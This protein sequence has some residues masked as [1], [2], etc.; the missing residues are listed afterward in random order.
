MTTICIIMQRIEAVRPIGFNT[1]HLDV[2]CEMTEEQMRYAFGE[3]L[4]N[5]SREELAEWIKHYEL[6]DIFTEKKGGT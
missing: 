6:E 2:E 1:R 4:K 5:V 3:F